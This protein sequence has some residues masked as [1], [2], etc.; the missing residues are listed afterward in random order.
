MQFV[1]NKHFRKGSVKQAIKVFLFTSTVLAQSAAHK[2][3][4]VCKICV[5]NRMRTR[6]ADS[7]SLQSVALFLSA[8]GLGRRGCGHGSPQ[9]VKHVFPFSFKDREVF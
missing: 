4:V 9:R 5:S 2:S 7:C 6:Q 1:L 8:K 3:F